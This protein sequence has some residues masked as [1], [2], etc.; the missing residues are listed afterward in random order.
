MCPHKVLNMNGYESILN[1][2]SHVQLFVT[3][4]TIARQALLSIEFSRQVYWS[5]LPCSAPGDVPDPGI[6]PTSPTSSA[7][8]A[9]SSSLHHFGSPYLDGLSAIIRVSV[10][11]GWSD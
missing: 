1:H 6:K 4:W 2:F 8:E 3:P 7:L 11:K 9:D 10:G 5:G